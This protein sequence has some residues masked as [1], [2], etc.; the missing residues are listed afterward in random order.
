MRYR[1]VNENFKNN[2]GEQLLHSRGVKDVNLFLNPDI[3][4]LQEPEALNN[5]EAGANLLH[6]VLM[7]KGRI[8]LVVDSDCDGF[9]SAAIM[10]Q[11][12]RDICE[13]ISIKYLLHEGKQHGLEDHI[14]SILESGE[15]YDLIILPDSSSNDIDYHE[16][17]KE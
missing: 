1:L 5:I 4:C 12:L 2:Y 10:Y 6:G 7:M 17:L 8:L 16:Q 13:G 3:S 15:K 9:T 11:Y 14:N